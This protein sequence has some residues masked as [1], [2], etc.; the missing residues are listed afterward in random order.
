MF[1]VIHKAVTRQE[2]VIPFADIL[3]YLDTCS[4]GNPLKITLP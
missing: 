4:H 1:N 3:P 2:D